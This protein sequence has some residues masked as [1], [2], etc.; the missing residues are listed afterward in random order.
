[1]CVASY[2]L[3]DE[4]ISPKDID[5]IHRYVPRQDQRNVSMRYSNQVCC[6]TRDHHH[7][8]TT[9]FYRWALVSVVLQHFR[10]EQFA[11]FSFHLWVTGQISSICPSDPHI[12]EGNTLRITTLFRA[13]IFTLRAAQQLQVM[14]FTSDLDRKWKALNTI[15]HEGIG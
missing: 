8:I 7:T 14:Y 13:A 15:I 2:L 3:V 4:L 12:E 11:H 1:M 6:D 5:P 9:T 10:C